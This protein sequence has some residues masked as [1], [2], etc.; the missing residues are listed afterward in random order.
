LEL[1][2]DAIKDAANNGDTIA[3]T[4]LAATGIA[5]NLFVQGTAQEPGQAEAIGSN[6]RELTFRAKPLEKQCELKFE[7]HDLVDG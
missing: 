6:R 4:D 7:K 1:V 5:R 3:V 2:D